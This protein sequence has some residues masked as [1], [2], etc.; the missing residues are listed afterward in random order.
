MEHYY[1]IAFIGAGNLA[2]HLAPELENFGHKVS[3]V[4]SRT[5]KSAR[6]LIDRLYNA[7]YKKNLDFSKTEVDAIIIAV[8]DSDIHD[9]V[10]EIIVPDRCSIFHTSGIQPMNIL[11]NA[12]AEHFGVLYPLQT[13]TKGLKVNFKDTFFFLEANGDPALSVLQHLL[14]GISRNIYRT[15]SQQRSI[16]HLS[17]VISSNFSNHMLVIAKSLMDGHNMDYRLLENV[18]SSTVRKAFEMGPENGQTGPAVRED[19]DTINKHL[20]LL[21]DDREV[22]KIYARIS[23]HIIKTYRQSR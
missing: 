7:T 9:V 11:E 23:E 13:F 19:T 5:K 10:T 18:V 16:L 17:A 12:A 3:L 1:N 8:K 4:N 6:T 22:Q 14:K 20:K 21:K 2:W 15:N